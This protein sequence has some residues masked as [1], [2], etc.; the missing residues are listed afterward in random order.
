[1]I[2]PNF[3]RW[4]SA[5][6][7]WFT[8]ERLYLRGQWT[9]LVRVRL[10]YLRTN[11]EAHRAAAAGSPPPPYPHPPHVSEDC[12]SGAYFCTDPA[13]PGQPWNWPPKDSDVEVEP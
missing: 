4:S 11:R 1:M 10:R 2:F 9:P 7:R 5:S 6:G 8:R 12:E 3:G 13:C